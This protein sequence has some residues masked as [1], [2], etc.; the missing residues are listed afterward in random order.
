MGHS[1]LAWPKRRSPRAGATPKARG[2][3]ILVDDNQAVRKLA[4][5][6]LRELGYSVLAAGSGGAALE[7]LERSRRSIACRRRRR[8]RR[9]ETTR[10]DDAPR[11]S[12]S[13][14]SPVLPTGPRSTA[15][16]PHKSSANRFS[17]RRCTTRCAC[18]GRPSPGRLVAPP[19]TKGTGARAGRRHVFAPAADKSRSTAKAR[20]AQ[21]RQWSDIWQRRRQH[22]PGPRPSATCR[23]KPPHATLALAFYGVAGS[24][25]QR[26]HR[27]G[28]ATARSDENFAQCPAVDAARCLP[29]GRQRNRRQRAK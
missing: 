6:T 27:F 25:R 5:A 17:T 26:R 29:C 16:A 4:P 8:R 19:P 9:T 28:G 21:Q 18:R 11:H 7:L 10:P 24:L 20:A 15:S 1:F 14:S 12:R 23:N 22:A 3:L 13:C 2:S